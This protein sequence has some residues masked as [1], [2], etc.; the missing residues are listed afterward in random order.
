MYALLRK[1]LR[2]TKNQRGMT[3]I[4]L[5]AV[6]I[7]MGIVATV[8]GAA[9][10]GSFN[11]SKTASTATSQQ[12]I[13]EAV[14]RYVMDSN[15]NLTVTPTSI[16]A[17]QLVSGGYLRDIPQNSTGTPLNHVTVANTA[18]GLTIAYYSST[19]E[20]TTW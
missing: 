2:F 19:D 7:I 17:V 4:E 9:V 18:A 15:M 10:I 11:K 1:K 14:Q 6:V 16:T 3:L 13:T 8:A 5:S 20:T 12:V